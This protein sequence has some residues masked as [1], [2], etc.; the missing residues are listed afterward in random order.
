MGQNGPNLMKDMCL[1]ILEA[2]KVDPRCDKLRVLHI[3]IEIS[4]DKEKI[5]KAEREK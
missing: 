3:I 2:H 4:K 1:H 5:L